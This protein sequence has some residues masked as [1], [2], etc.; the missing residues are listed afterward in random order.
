MKCNNILEAIGNTP[1][2]RLQPRGER[3]EG[4]SL[5]QSRLPESRRLG[6]RPHRHLDDRRGR[7]KRP[8]EARRHD[9]RRHFGQHGN[10]ARAGRGRARL[11]SGLHHHRQAIA[12]ENRSAES[13]RRG[14]D[15]LPDGGRAGRSAQLLFRGEK[16]GARNSQFVLSQSVR[17][18]DES[19]GALPHHGPGNLERH[20]RKNHAL[21]LRHGNGR[22]DQR[23]GAISEGTESESENYRRRS[24]RLALLRIREDGKDRQGA[25]VRGGR[26]RRR[27]FPEHDGLQSARRRIAGER[28][29]MFRLGAAARPSSEGIFTGGSGGGCVAGAHASGEGMQERRCDRRVSAGLRHA[30]P[31]QDLQRRLDARVRLRGSRSDAH[32]RGRDP[33]EAGRAE[34]RAS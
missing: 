18:S 13:V 19:G 24:L 21:R 17:K 5:R 10:G 12:R 23:R 4:R 32:G 1:L 31:Q 22:D 14:S 28:R 3:F 33:R 25:D 29:G 9:H 20:R 30:L 27:Y 15:R 11:Q 16:T 2:I 26:N 34:R 8:A 6:E 7:A